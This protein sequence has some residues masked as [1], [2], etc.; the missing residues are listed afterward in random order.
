MTNKKV[1]SRLLLS[2]ALAGGLMLA[3]GTPAMADR[4]YKDNCNRRLETDRARIDNDAKRHGEHSRQA[5]RDVA[6]MDQDRKW[7]RDH[8]A[9]WDHDRFDVGIYFRH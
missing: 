8:K 1:W 9:E 6:K 5:D 3:V 2:T 7:C 4:D